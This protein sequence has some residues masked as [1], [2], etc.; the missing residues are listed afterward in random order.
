METRSILE[1][2]PNDL[3]LRG[4]NM[5]LALARTIE[6]ELAG[7][8]IAIL[9][10]GLGYVIKSGFM[11]CWK[12]SRTRRWITD[13]SPALSRSVCKRPKLTSC[14]PAKIARISGVC[15]TNKVR[16]P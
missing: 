13:F 6:Q 5:D 16:M 9:A 8:C 7:K 15:S 1:E 2:N 12:R 3:L 10:M 4:A 11:L 14:A